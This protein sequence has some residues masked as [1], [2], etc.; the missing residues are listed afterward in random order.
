MPFSI[1]ADVQLATSDGTHD[2]MGRPAII[3]GSGRWAMPYRAGISHA[4][5]TDDVVHFKISDDEGNTWSTVDKLPNGDSISG[6]PLTRQNAN[7]GVEALDGIYASNGHW[8]FYGFERNETGGTTGPTAQYGPYAFR[9]TNNMATVSS[10]GKVTGLG[11]EADKTIFMKPRERGGTLYIPGWIS[12]SGGD[13]SGTHQSAIYTASPSDPAS[14]TK[15]ANIGNAGTTSSSTNEWD[16]EYIAS[17]GKWLA[18]FRVYTG[19]HTYLRWS[20][21]ATAATWGSLIDVS[22]F[23]NGGIGQPQLYQYG[24]ESLVAM[25]RLHTGTPPTGK[26]AIWVSHDLGTTWKMLPFQDATNDGGYGQVVRKSDGEWYG[27]FY[28]GTYDA[29]DVRGY[30]FTLKQSI[31]A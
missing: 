16:L 2:W 12:G 29:C 18:I 7:V 28:Y 31:A 5:E 30:K 20:D 9:S 24:N 15:V 25:G 27:A 11:A 6:A 1:N 13:H 8:I 4:H 17:R 21:D 3:V 14:I 22:S 10:L 19:T 26:A 23:F